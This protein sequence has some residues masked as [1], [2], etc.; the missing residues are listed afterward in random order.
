MAKRRRRRKKPASRGLRR[1]FLALVLGGI[2]L[3]W[4]GCRGSGHGPLVRLRIPERASFAQ[5]TDSLAA[6]HIVRAPLLFRVY[7]Y[8]T[9]ASRHVNPGTYG[10]HPGTGWERV[11]RALEE[12]RVLTA[13]LVVPEGWRLPQ[14]A[15]RL[16][17]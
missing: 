11:L 13:K 16:A 12:G 17:R 4:L 9:G 15:D 6:H 3:W 5:V 2:G 10:F 8:L 7:A 14:I 1:L